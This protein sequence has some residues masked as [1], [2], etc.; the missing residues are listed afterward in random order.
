M[1]L[2][3]REEQW[4]LCYYENHEPTFQRFKDKEALMAFIEE[5]KEEHRG[6]S[7]NDFTIFPPK[8]DLLK[9][10]VAAYGVPKMFLS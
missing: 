3:L 4:F 7:L 9:E 2:V 8:T 6:I 5:H 10:H 1:S